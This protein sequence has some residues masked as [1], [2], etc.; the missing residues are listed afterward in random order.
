MSSADTCSRAGLIPLMLLAGGLAVLPR[1]ALAGYQIYSPH[2][3]LGEIEVEAR[4]FYNQDDNAAVDGTGELKLSAGYG[5]THFWASEL[6]FA[7]FKREANG[8]TR[9]KAVEWENRFQLTP[10]GKYWADLGLLVE[11]EFATESGHPHE[12]KVGPLVEKSFG[13]TVATVNLFVE[14]E[15]GPHAGSETEFGYAARLRYRLNPYFEPAIEA[16]GSPGDIGEFAPKGEQRHQ[17]GPAF[18]GQAYFGRGSRKFKYSAAALYGITDA[19]SP[20]W[21]F[22]VRF[23]YEFH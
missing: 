21:T 23:E 11:T 10:Q 17:I 16:Y 6:Y 18:Y 12:F 14:R 7:K 8:N 5:F 19:G 13:R 15:F 9:L 2:V 1:S 3:E 4:G 20:N 22:V